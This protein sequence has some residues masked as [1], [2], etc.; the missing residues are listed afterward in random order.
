MV[1]GLPTTSP[2]RSIVDALQAGTQPEQ[3]ELA[4]RQALERGVTTPRRLRAAARGRPDR[5]RRFVEQILS[6]ETT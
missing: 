6:G 5:I 1:H 3:I 2:A 4:A